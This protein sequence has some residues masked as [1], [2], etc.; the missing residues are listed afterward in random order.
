MTLELTYAASVASSL[1]HI[2]TL[3]LT[4]VALSL[5]HIMTLELTYVASVALF[6]HK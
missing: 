3:E 6:A 2:M 5:V 4:Y 1:L